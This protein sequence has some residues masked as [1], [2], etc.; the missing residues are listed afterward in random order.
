MDSLPYSNPTINAKSKRNFLTKF[1][2]AGSASQITFFGRPSASTHAQLRGQPFVPVFLV[3]FMLPFLQARR[4]VLFAGAGQDDFAAITEA[5]MRNE[6]HELSEHYKSG[7][8]S[9]SWGW[10]CL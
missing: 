10:C 8:F 6:W 7:L 2:D 9:C 4:A 3:K 5:F 1:F